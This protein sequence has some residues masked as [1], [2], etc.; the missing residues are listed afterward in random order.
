MRDTQHEKTERAPT[1]EAFINKTHSHTSAIEPIPHQSTL[2]ER[3]ASLTTG[4]TPDSISELKE[5]T[6]FD[7]PAV[8]APLWSWE[9]IWYFFMGGLAAGSYVLASIATLFGKKEDRIV[10][11]VGYYASLLALLPCPPLL[12]KDLGRPEKFLNML[13][14]FKFKSP[15]SM[16]VWGLLTFSGFSG[17]TA[18]VQASHDGLLGRWWGTRLLSRIP[19]KLLAIPGSIFG[20][21][22]GGYT[23]VLLTVTSIPVWSRSKMLGALFVSSA[24]STSTALISVI[25]RIIGA[26]AKTLY[27]LEKIE[28][29]NMLIEIT[30]LLTYLRTAGRTAKAL[31]GSEP[32]EQGP[33]FWTMMF[34]GGLILPWLLQTLMLIA[35]SKQPRQHTSQGQPTKRGGMGLLVSLLVLMGG[36]FLR[37]TVV[38][39]GHA[40]S[41]DARTTLWNARR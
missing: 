22:L 11:R 16:G 25:L 5:K 10:A 17:I 8:K 36:Y 4:Y 15:M 31:V 24:F 28:W 3:L 30:C 33:T 21:F 35:G 40:S 18:M 9:I 2:L 29:A 27:K 6:Y 38:N 19:L 26:P 12:I 32:K 1:D 39:A 14:V 37:R 13:R 7:Y 34:G 41:A 20:V 23:G